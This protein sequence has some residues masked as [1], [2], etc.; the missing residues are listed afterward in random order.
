MRRIITAAA[1]LLAS[2]VGQA[3]AANVPEPLK[4]WQEWVLQGQEFRRCPF[5]STR[6]SINAEAYR[7]AWPGALVLDLG[8]TGGEFRQRWQVYADAWVTLPGSTEYWPR[9]LKLDGN[10]APVVQRE[11][12][13]QLYLAAGTHEITGRFAWTDRP[14]ALP[15]ARQTALLQLTL[16]GKAVPQPERANGDV[17]LGQRRSAVERDRLDVA[18]YRLL[19]DDIP[20][21]IFTRLQLFVSGAGREVLLGPVLPAG[22]VPMALEGDLPARLEPDGRL[23]VQLRPG[24]FALTLEARGAAVAG[25]ITRPAAAEPWPTDEVW[26]FRS[27]DNLRVAAVEGAESIDPSQAS[28]PGE[29]HEYPAFRLNAGGALNV[30][31][32]SRALVNP[33]DNQL[34][35]ERHLWLDFDHRGFTLTD[36]VSGKLNRDWRLDLAKPYSLESARVRGDNLLVTD[37]ANAASG[38]ELRDRD[39]QLSTIGRIDGPRAS[40]PATGWSTRFDS[41]RGWLH[42]PPGHRLLGVLG[43]DSAPGSWMSS[44]GLWNLFGVLVVVVLTHWVAGWF[45][46]AV[47]AIALLLVYQEMPEMIWLW[48]NLLAAIALVRAVPE[49]KLRRH[50][51]RY[52]IASFLVLALA[53]L[54]LLLGQLRLAIYPQLATNDGYGIVRNIATQALSLERKD[55]LAAPPAVMLDMP[56]PAL[57]AIE[58]DVSLA[59]VQV[60]GSRIQSVTNR[61]A[62]GT[63]LQAGPGVPN[64]QYNTYFFSW[65][66]PVEPSQQLR[67]IFVGPVLLGVWRILGIVASLLFALLLLRNAFDFPLK[68]PG[69]PASWLRSRVTAALLLAGLLCA[70]PAPRAAAQAL[71]TPEMLN[72]L[73]TRLTQ[74]ATCGNSCVEIIAAEVRADGARLEVSL[75]V[76]ALANLAVALPHAGDRWQLD[77]VQVDGRAAPFAL[78][79]ADDSAW[80]PLS[81]GAH[82][83]QLA[84]RLANAETVQLNFPQAP[85]AITV[86][87]S[88]WDASGVSNGRLLAG[89]VELI[90][91]RV[92]GSAAAQL[93][94]SEFAPFV[95]VRREFQLDLDWYVDTSVER[96]APRAAPLQVEVPLVPGESVLSDDVEVLDGNRV[97]VGLAR[98][99]GTRNWRSRLARSETLAVTLPADAARIEQWVFLA[100]P[101]W[102]LEFSGLPASL[103]EEEGVR[104]A[105]HFIP[106]AGETLNVTIT[107]PAATPGRTLALD[108]VWHESTFGKRAVNGKLTLHY[109]STQGGRHTLKLPESLRV[110]QVT[111]DGNSVPVRPDKGELPLSLLVGEHTV[112]IQW[113][114]PRGAGLLTKPDRIE[115][116]APA[117]NLTTNISLPEDRWPLFTHGQG[118]GTVVLYW[119]EVA[120]FALLAWLL[121]LRRGSPLPFR[122]WLLLGLGLSTL[123]WTVFVIVAIWLLVMRWRTD[124]QHAATKRW[125]FNLV[126]L[127]LAAITVIAVTSLVFSGVRYGL[128][129]QPDMALAGPFA[130]PNGFQWFLDRTDSLLPQPAVLSVPMWVYRVLMFAWAAWAAMAL[131]RWVVASWHAWIAG[132]FWRAKPPKVEAK[133]DPSAAA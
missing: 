91:R 60:T 32:R 96:L 87:A 89:S 75:S 35:L 71:P 101:E 124:W 31:E 122:D 81:P 6:G 97:L 63:L 107:R 94:P 129:A 67:F 133:A 39:L 98:G 90:R 34:Q 113:T 80:L 52:R 116:G 72:E 45:A 100:S 1:I 25:N 99:E 105:W 22:F 46:A 8:A 128:L 84:G 44:W 119:G 19:R 110:T 54:P 92:A 29:W 66:G 132:G 11:G 114:A 16:D 18:V 7:C 21:R 103:P 64:W 47:A 88:G 83:V 23:R 111:V 33:D 109:R 15:V 24:S 79:E 40:L 50:A 20:A 85:R 93:A 126:Q 57:P 73:K 125:S 26:S 120:A 68:L 59:E 118:V 61:Y 131:R 82:R 76:S 41:V 30:V 112:E 42:L 55:A 27:V 58:A 62:D 95:Q 3:F 86:S 102:H 38:V 28:V 70:L 49:G 10:A 130:Y 106:R 104:W 108:S 12:R 17:W 127:A 51:Q 48:A 13:P 123:S 14:E 117:S 69:V 4:P 37:G 115:I 5:V 53:L 77:S 56:A 43:A 65:S 2:M 121:A 36:E 74:P 9:D 78:R